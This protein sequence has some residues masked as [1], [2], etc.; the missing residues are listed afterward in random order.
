MYSPDTVCGC[1]QHR[2][3]RKNQPKFGTKNLLASMQQSS[4]EAAA[5]HAANVAAYD[6]EQPDQDDARS[7]E[8][9]GD[10][11]V[12]DEAKGTGLSPIGPSPQGRPP[13]KKRASPAPLGPELKKMLGRPARAVLKQA[14]MTLTCAKVG[15]HKSAMG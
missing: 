3:D 12:D 4:R 9:E 5:E 1:K 7:A 14:S 10:G 13:S 15:P 11:A 6:E 8:G 2:T